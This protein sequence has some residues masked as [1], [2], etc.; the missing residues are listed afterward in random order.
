[1]NVRRLIRL[2]IVGI[3]SLG[4]AVALPWLRTDRGP[5]GASIAQAIPARFPAILDWNDERVKTSYALP[6]AALAEVKR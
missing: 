5:T 3:V 1:M 2:S 4:L 6:D